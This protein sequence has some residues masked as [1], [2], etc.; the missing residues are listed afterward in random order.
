MRRCISVLL[1]ALIAFAVMT[2]CDPLIQKFDVVPQQLN[3][4]GPVTITYQGQGN[5]LHLNADQPVS[6]AIPDGGIGGLPASGSKIETVSQTTEFTLYYPGAGHREKTVTVTHNNCGGPGPG[7]CGPAQITLNGTCL[8][9]Q[10]GPQY[11]TQNLTVA[12]APGTLVNITSNADFP[13]HVQHAGADIAIGAG[14]GPLPPG[15]PPGT[16]AAGSYTIYVPGQ[17]GV[18]VCQGAGP[19]MGSFPAPPV[20]LTITPTCPP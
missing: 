17:V 20:T 4:S 8:N 16:Q 2:G 3:C 15:I 6:P 19:T 5:D 13:V 18:L 1:P 10:S 7:T 14:G 9:A 12:V 11:D